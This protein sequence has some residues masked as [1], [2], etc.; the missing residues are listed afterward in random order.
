MSSADH[1]Q[2]PHQ[3]EPGRRNC[4]SAPRTSRVQKPFRVFLDCSLLLGITTA[5]QPEQSAVRTSGT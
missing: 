4:A 1:Y 2:I 5:Q 3:G